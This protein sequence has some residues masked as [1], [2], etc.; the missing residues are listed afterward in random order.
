MTLSEEARSK[1]AVIEDR[2]EI[3]GYSWHIV[4][5]L[6]A[7]KEEAKDEVEKDMIE[8]LIGKLENVD[9]L[10]KCWINL[11]GRWVVYNLEERP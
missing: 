7:T 10:V 3:I 9:S 8:D 1:I 2:D 4:E 6:E 11:L 5:W